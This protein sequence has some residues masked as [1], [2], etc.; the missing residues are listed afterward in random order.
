[1]TSACDTRNDRGE[2]APFPA[3]IS[4]LTISLSRRHFREITIERASI[5]D[6]ACS[7]ITR[8]RVGL[9][10]CYLIARAKSQLWF[11]K[12]SRNSVVRLS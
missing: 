1:M 8:D 7:T 4:P 10:T 12:N 6:R 3:A 5:Y 9:C 2:V 11:A